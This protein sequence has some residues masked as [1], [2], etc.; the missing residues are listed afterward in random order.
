MFHFFNIGLGLVFIL[1]GLKVYKPFR[2]D[3]APKIAPYL[4]YYTIG[5]VLLIAWGLV[6]LF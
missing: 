2:P 5:G 3:F 6:N 4:I 1:I